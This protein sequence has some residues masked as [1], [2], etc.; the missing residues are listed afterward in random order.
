MT[1]I[2]SYDQEKAKV[3]MCING[4]PRTVE[5]ITR[6]QM[7]S[8]YGLHPGDRVVSEMT[9]FSA[10]GEQNLHNLSGMHTYGQ[11][12]E[13]QQ[14]YSRMGIEVRQFP[15]AQTPYWLRDYAALSG[16][17]W[18]ELTDAQKE[19]W[20]KLDVCAIG[21]AASKI[22]D[23]LPHWTPRQPGVHSSFENF[24]RSQLSEMNVLIQAAG[25]AKDAG[26]HRGETSPC[27]KLLY[28]TYAEELFNRLKEIGSDDSKAAIDAFFSLTSKGKLSRSGGKP[29]IAISLEA[30]WC[31]LVDKDGFRRT[32]PATG[33]PIGL[34][35]TWSILLGNKPTTGKKRGVGRARVWYN[36]F[37]AW[38]RRKG[39]T[40]RLGMGRSR[41]N[42]ERR[43]F[44]EE[45]RNPYANALKLVMRELAA[46]L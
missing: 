20:K 3:A 2:I 5:M 24:L 39:A 14:M 10:R 29:K 27:L 17:V 37:R 6:E 33:Q 8:G 46:M 25:S 1:R 21:W 23:Q 4:D 13:M 26:K 41:E 22:W 15:Q 38:C 40:E 31:A 19:K 12:V 43:K 7:R 45:Y 44:V 28:D 30:V 32:N 34:K 9:S 42:A 16:D 18:D 35:P 36:H 11:L